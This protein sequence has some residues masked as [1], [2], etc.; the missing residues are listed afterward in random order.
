M[1]RVI[2]LGF[3]AI[4]MF[5][6]GCSGTAIREPKYIEDIRPV[7]PPMKVLHYSIQ[8]KDLQESLLR[9]GANTIR[10]V[11]V[12]ENISVNKSYS[13]RLFDVQEGSA[14]AL[15]GLQSSDVVVAADR[16]LLKRA[17][18]F[19]S[20]VSL[21]AGVDEASIEIRRGGESKL[22]KYNFIPAI[23]NASAP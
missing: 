5:V 14:Y 2:A 4:G 15:L 12:F 6:G 9:Q 13:Y 19:P 20:F 8:R 10:L 11:P 16:Y 18:Q 22:F 7:P 3:A 17:D 23:G 1:K 21:L